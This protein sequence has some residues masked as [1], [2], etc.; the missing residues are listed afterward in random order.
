MKDFIAAYS[1]ENQS[2][3]RYANPEQASPSIERRG[4]PKKL[5]P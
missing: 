3:D 1:F 2:L 4:L 5:K